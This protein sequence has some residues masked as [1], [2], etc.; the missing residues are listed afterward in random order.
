[1]NRFLCF[2]WKKAFKIFFWSTEVTEITEKFKTGKIEIL[3]L[4]ST[5]VFSVFSVDKGL[6]PLLCA[7]VLI[8]AWFTFTNRPPGISPRKTIGF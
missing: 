6:W 5:S 1:M 8:P 2:P 3:V 4:G 7:F